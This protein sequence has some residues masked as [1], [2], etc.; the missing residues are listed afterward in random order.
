MGLNEPGAGDGSVRPCLVCARHTVTLAIAL[1]VIMGAAAHFL[2]HRLGV[3]T[4]GMLEALS[5]P[6]V[7]LSFAAGTL[8]GVR[9]GAKVGGPWGVAIV[10]GTR[11]GTP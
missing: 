1:T 2:Q 6:L 4:P 9:V 5:Q 11:S 7:L 8:P 10:P 3:G